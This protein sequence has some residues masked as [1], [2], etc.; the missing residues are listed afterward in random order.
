M[1]KDRGIDSGTAVESAPGLDPALSIVSDGALG[2]CGLEALEAS[3]YIDASILRECKGGS[4]VRIRAVR[5]RVRV[6]DGSE[7]VRFA[8]LLFG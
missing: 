8:P 4:I 6:E 2:N 1:A 3:W 7:L 5:I